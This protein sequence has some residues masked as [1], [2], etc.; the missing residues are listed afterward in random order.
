MPVGKRFIGLNLALIYLFDNTGCF[1]RRPP[2]AGFVENFKRL[3]TEVEKVCHPCQKCLILCRSVTPRCILGSRDCQRLWSFEDRRAW[4]RQALQARAHSP[5]CEGPAVVQQRLR[6]THLRLICC[7]SSGCGS[8]NQFTVLKPF[9][10]TAPYVSLAPS[11][12]V[13]QSVAVLLG[14]RGCAETKSI[15][16]ASLLFPTVCGGAEGRISALLYSRTGTVYTRWIKNKQS[17]FFRAL[18]VTA[19]WG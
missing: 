3:K 19:N 10:S 15:S 6:L 14:G 2:F 5:G 16:A 7:V 17:W 12:L 18:V 8:Q 1:K 4:S 9:N 13:F 11:C